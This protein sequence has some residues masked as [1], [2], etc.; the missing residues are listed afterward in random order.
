VNPLPWIGAALAAIAWLLSILS[1]RLDR[2]K[3]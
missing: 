2:R 3:L 1:G